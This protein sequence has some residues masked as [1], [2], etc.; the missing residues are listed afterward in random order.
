MKIYYLN[1]PLVLILLSDQPFL[2]K[3]NRFSSYPALPGLSNLAANT[4]QV[5]RGYA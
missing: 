5:T 3:M 1:L 2:R 4:A